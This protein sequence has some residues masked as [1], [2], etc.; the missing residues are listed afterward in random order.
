MGRHPEEISVDAW[1]GKKTQRKFGSG[2]VAQPLIKAER[3]SDLL[4]EIVACRDPLQNWEEILD[5]LEP[6][7]IR[8][9]LGILHRRFR[10]LLIRIRTQI[11]TV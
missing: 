2:P 11:P 1:V 6:I 3:P 5:N 7:G 8:L 4:T 9:N 10:K